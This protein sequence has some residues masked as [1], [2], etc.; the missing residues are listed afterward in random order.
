[1]YKRF[2]RKSPGGAWL[3]KNFFGNFFRKI[4]P[5]MQFGLCSSVYAVRFMQFGLCTMQFGLCTMQFGLCTMHYAVRFMQFGLCTMQYALCTMHYAVCSMQYAV[6]SM[7]SRLC[8]PKICPGTSMHSGFICIPENP[9]VPLCTPDLYAV[10]ILFCWYYIGKKNRSKIIVDN[11]INCY[12]MISASSKM[13]LASIENF[14][15]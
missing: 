1:M 13:A 12:I 10:R 3:R 5:D 7:Q 15:T 2:S 9:Q 6:C 14:L 8:T 11:D 4:F